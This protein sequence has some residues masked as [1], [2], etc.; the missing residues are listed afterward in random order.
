MKSP[1]I[2]EAAIADITKELEYSKF[3]HIR[4]ELQDMRSILEWIME[5]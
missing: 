5:E 2:V 4:R 1:K 3:S